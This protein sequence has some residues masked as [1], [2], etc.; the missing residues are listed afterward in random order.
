MT[1]KYI[2]LLAAAILWAASLLVPVS[3]HPGRTDSNG[4]HTDHATGE[5]HYHHGY[6]AH[7]HYD[8][9]GDGHP[10]CPYNFED[11]T[12]HGSS[13]SSNENPPEGTTPPTTPTSGSAAS[14]DSTQ[15]NQQ[16]KRD[17]FDIVFSLGYLCFA[18]FFAGLLGIAWFLEKKRKHLL[19]AYRWLA[20][21]VRGIE[22]A[23]CIILMPYGIA[24]MFLG[25]I[26]G[27]VAWIFYSL[28]ML[29]SKIFT[30]LTRSE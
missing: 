26:I 13:S 4:G 14:P 21:A 5:Y 3:A 18:L 20:L 11:K 9:D 17:F 12:N 23:S 16:G 24:L 1:R 30:F 6:P 28:W 2:I 10:D 27:F 29:I 25:A 22:G 7:D 15:H 8:M 19:D